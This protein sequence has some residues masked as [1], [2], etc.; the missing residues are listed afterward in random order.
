MNDK[1]SEK[2]ARQIADAL[3]KNGARGSVRPDGQV[4]FSFLMD[5]NDPLAKALYSYFCAK[6]WKNFN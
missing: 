3:M 6:Q 4:S 2:E 5:F 1:L